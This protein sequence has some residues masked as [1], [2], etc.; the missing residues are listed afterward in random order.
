M[1]CIGLHL[2]ASMHQRSVGVV[3]CLYHSGALDATYEQ[4]E[5][6]QRWAK[7]DQAMAASVEE[8]QKLTAQMRAPRPSPRVPCLMTTDCPPY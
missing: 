8:L 3:T 4:M 5:N 2:P 6:H 1:L 7:P